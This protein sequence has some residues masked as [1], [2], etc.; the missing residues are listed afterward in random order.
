M[1]SDWLGTPYSL[2]SKVKTKPKTKSLNSCKGTYY[3]QRVPS[4]G[5]SRR[6]K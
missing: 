3:L 1:R 6:Q 4:P 2:L 5:P